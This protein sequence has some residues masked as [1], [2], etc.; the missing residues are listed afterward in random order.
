MITS[1]VFPAAP[2]PRPSFPCIKQSKQGS[3]VLFYTYKCGVVIGHAKDVE[4]P[5]HEIG[6]HSQ[7]WTMELFS[8]ITCSVTLSNAKR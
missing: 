5:P 8:D 1:E 2:T 3:I 4:N 7:D 6:H